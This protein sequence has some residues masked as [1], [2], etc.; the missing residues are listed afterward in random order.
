MECNKGITDFP[1]SLKAQDKFKLEA[2]V[3][4]Q[5]TYNEKS[6]LDI[7]DWI[8]FTEIPKWKKYQDGSTT[9]I[10]VELFFEGITGSPQRPE[11]TG[12]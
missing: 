1:Q 9:S 3:N 12:L 8:L 4:S 5:V 11:G 6:Q 10:S 2:I 7:I